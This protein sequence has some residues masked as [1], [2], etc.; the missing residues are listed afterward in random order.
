MY[1]QLL[2]WNIKDGT[3]LSVSAPHGEENGRCLQLLGQAT[4]FAAA[5]S[6][7]QVTRHLHVMVKLRAVSLDGCAGATPLAGR[8]ERQL[9][10]DVGVQGR[11]GEMAEPFV[12][13]RDEPKEW[14]Q[15]QSYGHEISIR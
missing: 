8:Q 5:V 11:A 2:L 14:M 3:F 15:R 1:L 12:T 13:F 10:R 6:E 7:E 9:H 4:S